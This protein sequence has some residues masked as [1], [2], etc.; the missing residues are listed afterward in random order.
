MLLLNVFVMYKFAVR[1]FQ[2]MPD[3]DK[4]AILISIIRALYNFSRLSYVFITGGF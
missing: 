1:N 2:R 4:G 3:S